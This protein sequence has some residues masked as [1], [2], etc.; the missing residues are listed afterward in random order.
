MAFNEKSTKYLMETANKGPRIRR[1]LEQKFTDMLGSLGNSEDTGEARH[2]TV[3]EMW[4]RLQ[5]YDT[6]EDVIQPWLLSQIF[7][8]PGEG[9]EQDLARSRY[10]NTQQARVIMLEEQRKEE[11][12]K[13]LLRRKKDEE[14]KA[15]FDWLMP[16]FGDTGGVPGRRLDNTNKNTGWLG[17]IPMTGEYEG[18]HMTELSVGTPGSEEGFYPLLVPGMPQAAIDNLAAGGEATEEDFRRARAWYEKRT[19]EGKSPFWEDG[20]ITPPPREGVP[21]RADTEKRGKTYPS[22]IRENTLTGTGAD[23]VMEAVRMH[24]AANPQKEQR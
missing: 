24:N 12:R 15:F 4:K 10:A 7:P 21:Y 23:R 6:G 5:G 8:T 17:N 16:T 22:Y 19:S 1:Q 20:D 9:Y 2:A 3:S 18:N 13:L 14:R 11:R